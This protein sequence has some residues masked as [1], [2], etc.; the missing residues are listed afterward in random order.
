MRVRTRPLRARNGAV[1]ALAIAALLVT[2]FTPRDAWARTV[3]VQ[4]NDSLVF[5]YTVFTTYATPNGNQSST[6]NNQLGLTVLWTD[7]TKPQGVVAYSETI[8]EV[9]G[10]QVS[11]PTAAQNTTTILDPYDNDTYLGNIGFYP[12]TYTDLKPGSANDLSVSLAVAGTPSG[13]L[14]G[15][16]EVNATVGRESGLISVNFTIFATGSEPPS[17]TV[18]LYNDTTGVLTQGI[19]YTHFFNVEKNFIYKLVSFGHAPT[20]I[21]NPNVQILIVAAV[22]VVAAVATVW[23]VT[24]AREK[25]KFSKARKKMGR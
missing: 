20:G 12:F 3:G 1:A 22:I 21:F 13:T 8:T 14:T 4:A 23:R 7:T 19:T 2:S 24:S 17:Q 5:D 16:Q 6:Q 18:L 10:T 9:N 15:V 25:G 11:A